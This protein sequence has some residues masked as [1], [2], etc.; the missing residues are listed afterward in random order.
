MRHPVDRAGFRQNSGRARRAAKRRPLLEV[1][2]DRTLMAGNLLIV[3]QEPGRST[4][5]LMQYSQSGSQ[6]SSQVIPQP[7]GQTGYQ[8]VG[9]VSVDSTGAFDVVNTGLPG[10][11]QSY[12]STYSPKS[13]QWTHQTYPGWPTVGNI[14][15]GTDGSLGQYV[16]ASDLGTTIPN[17]TPYGIIRFDTTGGA[18]AAFVPNVGF[19]QLTVGLD[20]L[21]YGLTSTSSYSLQIQAFDPKTFNLVKTITIPNVANNDNDWRSIAVDASGQVLVADWTGMVVKLS[22]TG[23]VL[24]S[25][26][27]GN[28]ENLDDIALDSDG[29][30]AIGGRNGDVFLTDESLASSRTI[31]TG[32][33]DAFVTFAHYIPATVPPTVQ[34]GTNVTINAG[35]TFSG[36]GSFSDPAA[37]GQTF[38]A[39][40]NY[41]DGSGTQPLTLNPD[42][43]FNLSHVYQ[44]V[45][46]YTVTVSVTDGVGS[47]GTGTFSVTSV[48][49]P[50]TAIN[51]S[52]SVNP[53]STLTVAG[54]PSTTGA[55]LRYGFDEAS[56]GSVGAQDS[57][58]APAAPGTFSGA[59]TRTSNTPGS[60]S[61]GALDLSAPGNDVVSAGH[62]AKLDNLGAL[63][64]TGWINLRGTPT[65][66]DVILSDDPTLNEPAGDG[67]WDLRIA[68]PYDNNNPLSASN[69][70]LQFGV[71]QAK[72]GYVNT[73]AGSSTALNASG[74]WIFVAATYDA[75]GLLTFY[76]GDTATTVAQVGSQTSIGLPLGRNTAPFEIGGSA[77]FSSTDLT[78]PAWLDDLRVY[79]TALTA[80]Q[81]DQVR[82]QDL[83]SGV[84]AND[85]SPSGRPLTASL[86]AGPAH[87]ALTLNADGSFTYTPS[88]G[89][90]GTDSFTYQA[91]DGQL[92]SN[93]ATVSIVVNPP[94]TDEVW[95]DDSAPAGAT[96]YSDGGDSWTWSATN[97]TPYSGALDLQSSVATGEHQIYFANASA[98][99]AVP[100]GGTLYAYVYLDP[101]N[102]PQEVMLQ[103]NN[104]SWE[105]RAYWG[106]DD[107]TWGTDGTASRYSMG[108]L[109]ATGGWVRLTVQASLVGLE[110][111][112]LNGMAFTLYG[113][114][115]SWDDAGTA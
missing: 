58:V 54:L 92:T 25:A 18:S 31:A 110:G 2:E 109:P 72:G 51:D 35:S 93:V 61:P 34:A 40:V 32:Q 21:I 1:L 8:S 90:S 77:T 57:G 49:A 94:A 70:A 107:I 33:W 89:F 41:G 37:I 16:Y 99:L 69:F 87:G 10:G 39:T 115:A 5:Y 68:K 43:T 73:E 81:L 78:P 100:T 27:I 56:S 7:P 30:V 85:T 23:T 6:L 14:S 12:L 52:Y 9:G 63:T 67:G 59:A 50:P 101:A 80:A 105:H 79:G 64:L 98:T 13:G 114:R 46:Q 66:Q 26:R 112:T 113:G 15:Y 71:A 103:W 97:P 60:G 29:Q 106:A 111:Q 55:L 82:T 86:V 19:Y 48:A 3:D 96:L 83:G 4:F 28:G 95:V 91:N 102:P 108:A 38:T 47:P 36:T 20:G 76:E 22:P 65:N 53:G 17:G 75:N 45:G 11:N 84:L 88:P 42:Q 74:Q 104:G 44:A 62:V 24:A